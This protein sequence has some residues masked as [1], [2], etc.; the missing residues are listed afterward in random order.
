VG[1]VPQLLGGRLGLDIPQRTS[2]SR[3][4]PSCDQLKE[5]LSPYLLIDPGDLSTEESLTVGCIVVPI[6]QPC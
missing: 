1:S 3:L 6:S 4:F 2:R 5:T